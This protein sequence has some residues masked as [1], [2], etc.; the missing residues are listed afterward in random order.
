MRLGHFD[1]VGPLQQF[2]LTDVCSDYAIE[3]SQ[4]GRQGVV[5]VVICWFLNELEWL[6][7]MSGGD[8]VG[9]LMLYPSV[10]VLP[11][12]HTTPPHDTSSP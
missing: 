3:L 2:P 10:P 7:C 12:R 1:P 11:T 4:N 8:C 5:V 6:R 9:G